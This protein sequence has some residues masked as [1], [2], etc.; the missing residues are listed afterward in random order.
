MM[1]SSNGAVLH[2][3]IGDKGG[4][5]PRLADWSTRTGPVQYAMS[6][7]LHIIVTWYYI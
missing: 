6:D 7:F 5:K 4:A 1:R 3:G 2:D